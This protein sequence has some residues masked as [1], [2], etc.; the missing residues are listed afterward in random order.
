MNTLRNSFSK[1]DR[2]TG[3]KS[4]DRL[5][6]NGKW[7]TGTSLKLVYLPVS[8]NKNA[9]VQVLISVSKRNFKSAVK[10]NLIKRRIRESYR[11]QKNNVYEK[12]RAVQKSFYIGILYTNNEVQAYPVID[13]ELHALMAK[14]IK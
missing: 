5:F 2:L 12:L 10:R 11:L 14:L 6:K 9:P 8:Y 7:I 13:N 1:K 3:K 4:I